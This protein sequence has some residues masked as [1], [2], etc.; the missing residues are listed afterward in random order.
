MHNHATAIGDGDDHDKSL[1]QKIVATRK[2]GLRDLILRSL[3]T[4]QSHSEVA[5]AL[6]S[7]LPKLDDAGNAATELRL[8]A[9]DPVPA[10]RGV[11]V[12]ILAAWDRSAQIEENLER[13]LKDTEEQTRNAVITAVGYSNVRSQ[14]I[15][16]ILLDIALAPT[17][18]VSLRMRAVMLLSNDFRCDGSECAKLSAA[19][20]QINASL[21]HRLR[22]EAA[23]KA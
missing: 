14:R 10:V 6:L 9:G 16:E 4:G 19:R 22:A 12:C 11:S 2:S 5:M 3:E 8:L 23:R 17:E 7:E 13:G 18:S 20:L 1:F 15:K 21:S